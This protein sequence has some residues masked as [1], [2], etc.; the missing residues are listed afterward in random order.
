MK[1]PYLRWVGS[2][3]RILSNVL[4]AIGEVK[5]TFIE[6]F[7]GTG[8]VAMNVK[9]DKYVL[10]DLNS[11]LIRTHKAVILSPTEVMIKLNN[12]IALGRDAYYKLR[13]QFNQPCD[14]IT[15]ASLFIYLN[16]CGFQGLYRENLKGMFNTPVGSGNIKKDNNDIYNFSLNSDDFTTDDFIICIDKSKQ[17]DVI[18]ADPPYVNATDTITAFKYTKGG[19]GMPE[20]IKLRDGLLRA[21]ERDVRII[22]S[23]ADTPAVREL[24]KKFKITEVEVQRSVSANGTARGKIKEL[25]MER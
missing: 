11:K 13:D 2:K 7:V 6:P 22:A 14:D 19:F 20:Q 18:Y 21:S 3:Q 8:V 25:I 16:R 12:F 24:Y 17:G 9:A 10:N 15:L 5:G 23:N 1:K 4:S